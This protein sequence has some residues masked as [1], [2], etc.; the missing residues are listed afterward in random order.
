[1]AVGGAPAADHD[2]MTRAAFGLAPD[3]PSALMVARIEPFRDD[4]LPDACWQ[5]ER[6]TASPA[7]IE[8]FD[9]ADASASPWPLRFNSASRR[10]LRSASGSARRSSPLEEQQIEGEEDRDSSVFA[11]DSAACSAAK[12]GTPCSSSATTSP[13]MMRRASRAASL[14]IAANFA[15]PVQRPCASSASRGRPRCAIAGDSRRI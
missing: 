8:M 13:S 5:A 10:V 14:A 7:V 11:S 4:A 3:P 6:S 15:R 2:F 12:S 1:M 9:E